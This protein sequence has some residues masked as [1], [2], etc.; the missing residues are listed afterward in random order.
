[1]RPI[2]RRALLALGVAVVGGAVIGTP[3]EGL[4][5]RETEG[6]ELE[7]AVLSL[8]QRCER[9]G[10]VRTFAEGRTLFARLDG[11]HPFPAH[12]ICRLSLTMARAARWSRQD[13]GNWVAIAIEAATGVED[14]PLVARCWEEHATTM[15]QATLDRAV[16]A[17]PVMRGLLIA[18]AVKAGSDHDVRALAQYR[19]A[20]EHAAV[21][22]WR[23]AR[24]ALSNAETAAEHAGWSHSRRGGLAGKT[25]WALDELNEAE[26]ALSDG[27]GCEG[28]RRLQSLGWLARVHLDMDAPDAA[29]EDIL[30]ADY[31]TREIRRT[32]LVPQL[33]SVAASLPVNLR[34]IA[35]DHLNSPEPN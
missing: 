8:G 7:R 18:A 9:L 13:P 11:I 12:S 26:F 10:P 22:E 24:V 29:L 34:A 35:F 14:G 16:G 21:G 20:Y 6:K 28:S 15:G 17:G 2:S 31:E 33:R 4:A 3:L 5:M 25:L 23:E 1:M 30:Q 27:M 32:D 19:L